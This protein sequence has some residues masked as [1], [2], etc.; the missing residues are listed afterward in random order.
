VE[1]VLFQFPSALICVNQRQSGFD[2]LR[3]SMVRFGL[4][5]FGKIGDS[6]LIPYKEG[7]L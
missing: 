3:V 6:Q 4:S 1:K 5:V 2:F 7:A